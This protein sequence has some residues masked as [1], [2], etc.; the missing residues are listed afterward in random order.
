M[1]TNVMVMMMVLG[2]C[3]VSVSMTKA[4]EDKDKG[5]H[6]AGRASAAA[7]AR[8]VA[9]A[10]FVAADPSL[11]ALHI[12]RIHQNDDNKFDGK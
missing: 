6:A 9:A 4:A 5:A 8:E 10:A 7:S 11:A 3:V 12:R 2:R 1:C